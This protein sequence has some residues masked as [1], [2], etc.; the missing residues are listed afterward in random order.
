[1]LK[2]TREYVKCCECGYLHPIFKRNRGM[3]QVEQIDDKIYII[4]TDKEVKI[5]SNVHGDI[6]L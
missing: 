5:I 4:E 3:H 1:M 2:I 6:N